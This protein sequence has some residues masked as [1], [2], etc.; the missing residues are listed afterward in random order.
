MY[1]GIGMPLWSD[2]PSCLIRKY[3]LF[4]R[5]I[6]SIPHLHCQKYYGNLKTKTCVKRRE[7]YIPNLLTRKEI[8]FMGNHR[9][10]LIA[11]VLIAL[12]IVGIITTAWFTDY[13]NSNSWTSSMMGSG[14]MGQNPMRGMMQQMMPDLVPPGVNPED[15]PDPNSKGAQLIVYYCTACHNLP[16]PSMHSAEE[17]PVVADRMFRRMSRMSGGMM[18]NVEM[19][20]PEEQQ[21]IVAY[22]RAHSLTSI[23]PHKLPSPESQGAI[24]FKDRCSQCHDLPDPGRHTAKE[25]PTIVERMQGYMQSMNKKMI[26][27]NEEKQI[28]SYLSRYAQK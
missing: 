27:A 12:G 14:M 6:G 28:V 24:L 4:L 16:S 26:T 13:Q 23:S 15:L 11:A 25:W 2:R 1:F 5:K 22:L 3:T 17:W 19:P 21:D 10:F 18:M 20:S 9:T 8:W 7:I